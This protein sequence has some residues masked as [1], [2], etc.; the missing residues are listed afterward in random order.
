MKIKL[1]KRSSEEIPRAKEESYNLTREGRI[2]YMMGTD[3]RMFESLTND[4]GDLILVQYST[5]KSK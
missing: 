2:T 3:C 4:Y 5:P 1:I